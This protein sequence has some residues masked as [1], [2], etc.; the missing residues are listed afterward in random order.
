VAA[1]RAYLFS[2]G[3]AP[4][5][6]K[7]TAAIED[8]LR[9]WALDPS[10]LWDHLFSETETVR[11]RL[12]RLFGCSPGSIA[13]VDGTSRA[14][15]LA[16]AL[17]AAP[18]ES[19]V[20]IDATTYPSSLYP[21]LLPERSHVEL[22]RAP[23]GRAG[24]A[25]SPS[26]IERLVDRRTIAVSVTHVDPNSGVRQDLRPIADIAHA[27]GAMLIVDVA[28]SAGAIPVDAVADGIDLA[29]GTAMKWL[30]GPPG[31]GYLFVTPS[32]L[33]RS[34]APQVG[35]MGADLLPGDR[36][37]LHLTSDAR[38]HEL[39]VPNLLGMP[40]FR[41]GLDLILETGVDEIATH[42]EMLVSRCIAGLTDLDLRVTTPAERGL[43][44]GLV[45]VPA[46]DPLRLQ[47]FLRSRGVDVWGWEPGG[48]IRAD[49][50]LFNT[51][52][53][54]DQFLQGLDQYRRANGP[55]SI[56]P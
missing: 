5:S 7:V 36:P 32:L 12:A 13:I 1:T 45:V 18:P 8:W 48:F 2:G 28:Q 9:Q 10:Y 34:G 41:A 35:Y 49:F 55:S 16:V 52:G 46:Q 4:A 21:W 23:S 20:V 51:D 29:V 19:N 6:V 31:I 44:A 30:L 42:V 14:S 38:R 15:N 24:L 39:G 26:D 53:D 43:R 27:Q 11:E 22:R 50:H 17:L 47:G 33:D 56:Q 3:L 25:A 37:Q 54:V 40:G